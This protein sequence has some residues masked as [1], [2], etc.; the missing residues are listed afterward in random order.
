MQRVTYTLDGMSCGHCVAAVRKAATT[1]A[2]VTVE[3]VQLGRL[4]ASLDPAVT[5]PSTLAQAVADEGYAVL[6]TTVD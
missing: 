2:G 6:A 5:S 3:E 4:V 1:V